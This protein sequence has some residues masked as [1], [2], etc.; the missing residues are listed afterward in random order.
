[1]VDYSKK[2]NRV[3]MRFLRGFI[4]AI[5]PFVVTF[6]VDPEFLSL[7]ADKPQIISMLPLASALLLALDKYLRELKA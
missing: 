3:A 7:L 1:M 4:C 6:L 2:R 5:I